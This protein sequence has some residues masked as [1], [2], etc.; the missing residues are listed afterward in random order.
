MRCCLVA[1]LLSGAALAGEEPRAY[2]GFVEAKSFSVAPP[3]GTGRE[4]QT[5]RVEF[6][7]VGRPAKS[8]I[9]FEQGETG[10]AWSLSVDMR[11]PGDDPEKP[12]VTKG[13]AAGR[14]HARVFG[15]VDPSRGIVRLSVR[16]EPGSLVAKQTLS[17]FEKG[18]FQTFR[19][20][21]T[22]NAFLRDFDA[23]GALEEGGRLFQG[24]RTARDRSA[25]LE[26]EVTIRWRLERIDPDVVGRVLD[27]RGRPLAGVKILARTTNPARAKRKLPPIL[28]EGRS[29]ALGRFRIPA[30]LGFYRVEAVGEE[31]PDPAGTGGPLVVAGEERAEGVAIDFEKVPEI[32]FRLDVYRLG[33]LP[34]P[35]LLRGHFAGDV[36][37]YLAF[38]RERV[39]A[40]RLREAL[41]P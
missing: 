25:R 24:S 38:L 36:K 23:E 7:L 32:E 18:R 14:L 30:S 17:G 20:V 1:I 28:L 22:R 41:A 31:R 5:E 11:E 37:S 10:G 34:R 3:K 26:R 19:G 39:P 9:E 2:R 13:A 21:T 29:D 12:L 27:M 4:E 40:G 33:A 35:E 6:L 16:A 8:G 15:A